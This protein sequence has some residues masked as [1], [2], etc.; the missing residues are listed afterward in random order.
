MFT[1]AGKI[2][3]HFELRGPSSVPSRELSFLPAG[4][5]KT[6]GSSANKMEAISQFRH[7]KQP[8]ITLQCVRFDSDVC[9]NAY[10]AFFCVCGYFYANP[11]E[12]YLHSSCGRHELNNNFQIYTTI[13]PSQTNLLQNEEHFQEFGFRIIQVYF[14][15]SFFQKILYYRESRFQKCQQLKC[16]IFKRFFTR[17]GVF[18]IE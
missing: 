14:H 9:D 16:T 6:S 5:N 13:S 18:F 10:S 11:F 1:I 3:N 8:K 17:V 15:I 4:V 12:L 7:A 2:E